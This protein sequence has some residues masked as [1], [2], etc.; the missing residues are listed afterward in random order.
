M[1]HTRF[2]IDEVAY[3]PGPKSDKDVTP[4]QLA[5]IKQAY[6][7]A[8]IKSFSERYTYTDHA[9]I[10]VMRVRLAITGIDK[11]NAPLN[12]ATLALIGPVSNG[13]ASSESGVFNALT[14]EPIA[15]LATHTNANPINGGILEYF[16]KTGHA[17][18]VLADH[19]RQ[20]RQATDAAQPL[21][22]H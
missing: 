12:Y 20:L 8:A 18:S 6:R 22:A 7:D 21:L 14:G 15:A 16:T 9:D 5:D 17:K 3:I 13:G 19:A 4:E 2:M 1:T 11:A 10:D